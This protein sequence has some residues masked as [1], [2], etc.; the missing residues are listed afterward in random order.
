VSAAPPVAII[1]CGNPTRRDDGVGPDVI[2]RLAGGRL[3]SLTGVGLR[4]AGTDGMAVLFAARGCRSLV[5]VDACRSD[6]EPGAVFEVPAA[7]IETPEPPFLGT[8][9]LRWTH[10]LAA[11]R[12]IFGEDFPADA[13]IF[14]IEAENLGF[15]MELSASVAAAAVRVAARIEAKVLARLAIP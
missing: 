10:A 1:G 12:R 2:R 13:T 5:I 6:A 7:E 14:L 15:G 3:G 8:H 4:D 11:G 9:E